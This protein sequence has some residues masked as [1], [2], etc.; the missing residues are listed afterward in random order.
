MRDSTVLRAKL[1]ST[2]RGLRRRRREH[3]KQFNDLNQALLSRLTGRKLISCKESHILHASIHNE[4]QWAQSLTEEILQVQADLQ[5]DRAAGHEP[6]RTKKDVVTKRS[7]VTKG[8]QR[9]LQKLA[10]A[11]GGGGRMLSCDTSVR[12]L[13]IENA[14]IKKNVLETDRPKLDCLPDSKFP[15]LRIGSVLY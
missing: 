3:H 1:E 15:F 9:E 12:S 2:L 8:L 11:D 10:T 6:A 7:L 13:Q 4:L 14:D 5:P